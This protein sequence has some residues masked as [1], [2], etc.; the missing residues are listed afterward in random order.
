VLVAGR[1]PTAAPR[2]L[3]GDQPSPGPESGGERRTE[4]PFL[5]AVVKVAGA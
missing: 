4:P 2:A 3:I 5:C 1:P